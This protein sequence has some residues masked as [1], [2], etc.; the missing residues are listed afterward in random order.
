VTQGGD[1]R[2]RRLLVLAGA[3]IFWERLWPRLWP[4]VA[5][6]GAF[7][8]IALLDILPRLPVWLHLLALASFA[9]AAMA[10]AV[11]A[12]RGNR[13]PKRAL[14][15]RRLE[16]DSGLSH[17]PLTALDDRLAAGASD[18]LAQALWALHRQ[19]MAASAGRLAVRLPSPGLPGIEPWGLRCAVVLLLVI[20]LAASGGSAGE[21]LERA[22]APAMAAAA[23]GHP[24]SVEVWITPPAHTGVAPIFL[25]AGEGAGK[26][27]GGRADGEAAGPVAVPQGSTVLAQ[28][29]GVRAAPTLFVGDQATALAA[30]AEHGEG[31][32]SRASAYRAET[33]LS[34]GDRLAVRLGGRLLAGWPLRLVADEPPTVAFAKTP[35]AAGNGGL[36]LAYT[37]ADDYAVTG[38]V[39]E[40][41]EDGE[42]A[43]KADEGR[44][45]SA[46]RKIAADAAAL[47]LE[48]PLA[49]GTG[50]RFVG[51]ARE[52]L[53]A[54]PWAGAPVRMR[55]VGRDAIGQ[56]GVSDEV[57]IILPERAFTHPVAQAI[58]AERKRLRG[59][60][61]S[62]IR[63]DVARRL[64]AIAARPAEF[65][66]DI[67][68]SLALAVARARLLIDPG[69]SAIGSVRALLWAAALHL[70]EGDVPR[71]EQALADAQSQLMAALAHGADEAEID[72]L[73]DA[74]EQA[75]TQYL[76]AVAAEVARRGGTS[77]P[78]LSPDTVLGSEEVRDLVEMFREMVRTGAWDGARELMAQLQ[79]MLDGIR[80]GL[81]S[82]AN[83]A[84]LAEAGALMQ[85]LHELAVAQQRLLDETFA[86]IRE[87][88]GAPA[89]LRPGGRQ[90]ADEG[91]TA[92]AQVDLRRQLGETIL[93][94]DDL[95]GEVPAP[96]AAA[97]RAM[98]G[99][100]RALAAGG[101]NEATRQQS[102]AVQAL[103]ESLQG[104]AQALARRLGGGMALFA[105]GGRGGGDPFGRAP[106]ERGRGLGIG[107]VEIPERSELRRAGEI[108]D[109]LR[110]RAGERQ[111]PA[112]EL[113]YIE[114]LLR[115]F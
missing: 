69:E 102:E 89:D 94:L 81:D 103:R 92:A 99:A 61:P 112:A 6:V 67:V 24:R 19:R 40:I 47:R 96:L 88:N 3:A 36:A 97:D 74:F 34:A 63:L 31:D 30:L 107:D 70:E 1:R 37:A 20:G 53:S 25:S 111:R 82:S 51:T 71:A 46:S 80:A 35:T 108:L 114:R 23:A 109:E 29:S 105:A 62:P 64:E 13:L 79:A 27:D 110:R 10:A 45:D 68:V 38:V 95:A 22:V 55:L 5:I 75:L 115:R 86:R 93:R 101:L 15:R 91:D 17:R 90:D 84:D 52:D 42:P 106:G 66:D 50:K 72:R 14:C 43:E 26:G 65:M 87:R 100:V 11:H 2:Y 8:A 54:H 4:L 85:D 57:R 41:H 32:Q 49:T 73:T 56:T 33:V 104:A 39:A 60:A 12:W 77:A 9:A 28:V 16:R 21:R 7:V 98:G 83:R 113:E 18:P 78:P 76:N 59:D 48:L 58:I 44:Q